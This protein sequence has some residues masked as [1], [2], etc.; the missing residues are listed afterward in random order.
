MLPPG[1]AFT[2]VQN[3][4]RTGGDKLRDYV[5][6]KCIAV[7]SDIKVFIFVRVKTPNYLNY[8]TKR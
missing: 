6:M 7:C 1:G 5:V 2:H 3:F 4:T 8:G